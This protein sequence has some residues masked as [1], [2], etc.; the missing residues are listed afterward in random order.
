[1]MIIK[2]RHTDCQLY[3]CAKRPQ[4]DFME[5]IYCKKYQWGPKIRNSTSVSKMAAVRR[6][7]CWIFVIFSPKQ[8]C[9]LQIKIK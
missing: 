8:L 9:I 5:G 1:M 6:S 4:L 7:K 3:A 2:V